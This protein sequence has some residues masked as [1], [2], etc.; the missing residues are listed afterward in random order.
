MREKSNVA[1]D[2]SGDEYAAYMTVTHDPLVSLTLME[3]GPLLR[4]RGVVFGIK[5][6][7]LMAMVNKY[8]KGVS[9]SSILVAQGIRPAAGTAPAIEYK[10]KP[11]A[12]PGTDASGRSPYRETIKIPGIEKGRLLAVKRKL[13][14]PLDGM[15]VTGKQILI[16]K[17]EDFPLHVGENI[18]KEEQ[19][20]VIN[21]RAAVSGAL[22]FEHNTLSVLPI[23]EIGEDVDLDV[24]N[25]HFKGDVKIGREV[26]PDFFVEA[27]GAITLWGSAIACTLKAP[28]GIEVRGGI[29]GKNK[30]EVISGNDISAAFVEN[31]KLNARDDVFIKSGIIGAEVTCGGT[32]KMELPRSRILGST[33]NAGA[34][35]FAHNVGSRF[36]TS[37]RLI[38]GINPDRE[39]GYI[40]LKEHLEARMKVAEEIEKKYGCPVLENKNFPPNTPQQLKDDAAT[41]EFLKKELPVISRRLKQAEETMYDHEAVIQVRET[42]YPRVY[43]KIGKYHLITAK[44]YHHV[45]I[46]YSGAGDCLVV[47]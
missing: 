17:I 34:G 43:V 12:E 5:K 21:Y 36:D 24:G 3:L 4:A 10:F 18:S 11:A 29:V 26:L 20:E 37:T 27:A 13:I 9:S 45:T 7:V 30:G 8:K 15:T 1:I 32:L 31:A 39:R 16:P 46:K 33:I 28:D 2:I 41:W 23:L 22:R 14:P 38:A 35:I 47:E 42:L 44:E 6:D 19:A 40:K 25:I